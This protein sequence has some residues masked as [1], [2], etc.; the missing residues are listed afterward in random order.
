MIRT[1]VGY[2]G[3]AKSNPT[4]RSLGDHTE[5]LQVDFD[6]KI[7]SYNELLEVFW[8]SHNPTS[9][10]W[11]KQYRSI[12]LAHN[13]R[14]KVM[15]DES[16]ADREKRYGRKVFTKIKALGNFYRAEDYHQKY[17]LRQNSR[18]MKEFAAMYPEA[19]DFTDSTAAARI[20]AYLGG[21]G[22]ADVFNAEIDSYGLSKE[23]IIRLKQST[24]FGDDAC[25]QSCS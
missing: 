3:G 2:A 4:Y 14:Q 6:P 16:M 24:S 8:S 9:R 11:S 22:S 21:Q 1:R 12:I 20:N 17:R 5:T 25:S 7:I 13:D 18:L 23:S 15:A 10:T 19:E